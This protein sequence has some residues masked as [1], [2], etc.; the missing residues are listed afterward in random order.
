MATHLAFSESG[1]DSVRNETG[2]IWSSSIGQEETQI[3]SCKSHPITAI[4]YKVKGS[5]E[6]SKLS[7]LGLDP[8]Y[9]A[10]ILTHD[11]C[12]QAVNEN[13]KNDMK[14]TIKRVPGNLSAMEVFVEDED[15]LKKKEDICRIIDEYCREHLMK[16]EH[17]IDEEKFSFAD[18]KMGK[19][20]EGMDD[21]IRVSLFFDGKL[22]LVGH[23]TGIRIFETEILSSILDDEVVKILMEVDREQLMYLKVI[24]YP[25][26]I[27]KEFAV[28]VTLDEVGVHVELRGLREDV[29]NARRN[30][31]RHLQSYKTHFWSTQLKRDE[32]T[33]LLERRVRHHLNE[34]FQRNKC[35][36]LIEGDKM[37]MVT[38][39]DGTEVVKKRLEDALFVEKRQSLSKLEGNLF[40]S[41]QWMKSKSVV[42]RNN[43]QRQVVV[44]VEGDELLVT[45]LPHV[46]I[47]VEN[48]LESFLNENIKSRLIEWG[49]SE[50]GKIFFQHF[51]CE[52]ILELAKSKED[53]IMSISVEDDGIHVKGTES[54]ITDCQQVLATIVNKVQCCRAEYATFSE[55]EVVEH[56]TSS[57]GK[58]SLQEIGQRT[59]SVIHLK[60]CCKIHIKHGSIASEEADVI[61]NS[62]HTNTA[63]SV[64]QSTV[65]GAIFEKGGGDYQNKLVQKTGGRMQCGEIAD[66][67]ASGN[68]RCKTVYHVC[69]PECSQKP[70]EDVHDI[71]VKCLKKA[72]QENYTSLSFPALGTGV[73]KY[74]GNLS[75][76]GLFDAIV[77]F[78]TNTSSTSLD[79]VT[80]VLYEE[81][82]RNV[83]EAFEQEY[84]RRRWTGSDSPLVPLKRGCITC[85]KFTIISESEKKREEAKKK[86]DAEIAT[87]SQKTQN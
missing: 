26:K 43:T 69:L 30:V 6:E 72:Q 4:Q 12:L 66:T 79:T 1:Y 78:T 59:R 2:S 28:G 54:G 71:A 64:G 46:K 65:A 74:P 34:V 80:V 48:F 47:E 33:L 18:F 83:I 10:H 81:S 3:L 32:R 19:F 23:E 45:C 42:L 86:I 85:A 53:S 52:E 82:T 21:S 8:K 40:N 44:T 50:D 25:T 55:E 76:K 57:A 24:R 73:Y 22:S 27:S 70:Q 35:S 14:V 15:V 68:L 77:E 84:N 75:A 31:T 7:E 60:H 5:Q 61:V 58:R 11:E 56:F 13:L 62:V 63:V 20:L 67:E 38:K 37:F 41:E 9:L 51:N 49:C 36:Y 29:V 87:I 39:T 16:S 17:D